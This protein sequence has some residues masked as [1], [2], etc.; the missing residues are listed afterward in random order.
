MQSIVSMQR[1]LAPAY[2]QMGKSVF[3][4]GYLDRAWD[5][6]GVSHAQVSATD[7]YFKSLNIGADFQKAIDAFT[8][9]DADAERVITQVAAELDKN[10]GQAVAKAE[11][12]LRALRLRREK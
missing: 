2:Q 3:T 5:S 10:P 12:L 8:A 11:R 4:R 7:A 6:A 9:V 1:T